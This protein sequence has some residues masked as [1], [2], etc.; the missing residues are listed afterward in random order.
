MKHKSTAKAALKL[1]VVSLA[2]MLSSNANAKSITFTGQVEAVNPTVQI[3]SMGQPVA[4]VKDFKLTVEKDGIEC[5]FVTDEFAADNTYIKGAKPLCFFEW[6]GTSHGLV[7]DALELKGVLET[8]STVDFDYRVSI[9]DDGVKT[10]LL[11]GTYSLD[12]ESPEIPKIL[13]IVA[14]WGDEEVEG[15]E[16][17]NYS[18][19]R[20]LRAVTIKAE[21]RPFRQVLS[22]DGQQCEVDIDEEECRV[23]LPDYIPGDA[24]PETFGRDVKQVGVADIKG[25]FDEALAE[26]GIN[27]DYRSPE[28]TNF[29]V[30][31]TGDMGVITQNIEGTDFTLNENEALLVMQTPHAGK[32]GD[33]WIPVANTIKLHIQDG[34]MPTDEIEFNGRVIDF[35]VPNFRYGTE[36]SVKAI[37]EP[38]IANDKVVI[39]YS[40]N[41]VPDGIYRAEVIASDKF[42]NSRTAEYTDRLIDR[43]APDIRGLIGSVELRE[44]SGV[45]TYFLED[46][47]FFAHGGW[48]DG[49][50]IT[51]VKING[52]DADI[53]VVQ[54]NIVLLKRDPEILPSQVLNVE[55]VASDSGG[56]EMVRNFKLEYMMSEFNFN[57]PP[58]QVYSEVTE[59]DVDFYQSEGDKCYFAA[60]DEAAAALSLSIRKGCTVEFDNIPDGLEPTFQGRGYNLEGVINDIG[61]HEIGYTVYYHNNNGEKVAAYSDSM[62]I[63][64]LERPELDFVISDKGRI[65]E[66]LYSMPH[67]SKRLTDYNLAAANSYIDLNISAQGMTETVNYRGSDRF[68]LKNYRGRIERVGETSAPVWSEVEYEVDVQYRRVPESKVAENFT[69]V[70][71]P[72][73][74][75]KAYV[76]SDVVGETTT[77]DTIEFTANVGFYDRRAKSYIYDTDSMGEWTAQLAY[78]N[79]EREYVRIGDAVQVNA[80]G[81]AKF[82]MDGQTI[83]DSGSYIY[84]LMDAISGVP[85]F[86]QQ[87]DSRAHR[88]ETL[89]GTAIEGELSDV[90]I[91]EEVPFGTT[92]R[93]QYASRN[94]RD[95]SA[96][97]V[98]EMS[99]DGVAWS[100]TENVTNFFSVRMNEPGTKFYRVRTENRL[101]GVI[102]YSATVEAVGYEVADIEVEGD[103]TLLEGQEGTF[104]AVVADDLVGASDGVFEWSVDEGATWT[105]G[106]DTFNHM[107]NSDFYVNVRYRL[108]STS[109]T[110]GE[111]SYASD[112][113]KTRVL[114]PEPLR[115]NIDTPRY[116]EAGFVAKISGSA[117]ASSSSLN[118]DII[119]EIELP[120]GAVV[121]ASEVEYLVKETD[122][123]GGIATFKYSAWVNGLKAE[124]F[125]SETETVVTHRYE[126]PDGQFEVD[127]KIAVAPSQG[128][129][130]IN[131]IDT[132]VPGVEFT[133]EWLVDENAIEITRN[134]NDFIYFTVHEPGLHLVTVR[135]RDNRG[136]E[137]DFS[138]FVDILDAD[139]MEIEL[140][141]SPSNEFNRAPL[142][143]GM[144]AYADPGH[145]KDYADTY[146]WFLDGAE[147]SSSTVSSTD[148]EFNEAGSFE[149]KLVVTSEY[150]QVGEY[151]TVINVLPNI[152]PICLPELEDSGDRYYVRSNCTDEDGEIVNYYYTWEGQVDFRAGKV[153]Y[154]RKSDY[155]SLTVTIRAVDNGGEFV[156][157]DVSW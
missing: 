19:T 88:V 156:E 31:G 66:G 29:I 30:N 52:E 82:I 23:F 142:R 1:S 8:A 11:T 150:A 48:A 87:I 153:I 37:G 51:S 146:Q 123:V 32:D 111:Q 147:L 63:E 107:A 62:T 6:T 154:F 116:A 24:E 76:I 44:G 40:I 12:V 22:I 149:V 134:S 9:V 117:R 75:T 60:T 95:A 38:V 54:D 36:Y 96:G 69:A 109:E 128:S 17:E 104:T 127:T 43:F 28:V 74:R 26:V 25:Y 121:N 140:V 49:S 91:T 94:D 145:P 98:W 65:S 42:N 143:V 136:N 15:L 35:S 73:S 157:T 10:E 139:P 77:E 125:A 148:I 68:S 39:K 16:Q 81:E 53:D 33:W 97:V 137:R 124:T 133:Y 83:F 130:R 99:D 78:R 67:N 21:T 71:T 110:V 155:P 4:Y 64:A 119:E 2:L 122:I 56:N 131:G 103:T 115:V 7:V 57:N 120:D 59:M 102:S 14:D 86:E 138:E 132:D 106:T 129:A 55:V 141:E 27:Y 45:D 151:T 80:S 3:E 100:E 46:V 70:I 118:L 13:D 93:F 114:A 113:M 135:V 90:V 92:V 34:Q 5:D 61:T 58:P 101:T 108:D 89:K 41:D 79:D 112:K 152:P 126:F 47:A 84:V 18:K 20:N 72:D 144:R 105:E 85:G 50:T